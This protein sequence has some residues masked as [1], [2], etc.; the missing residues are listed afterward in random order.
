MDF[1]SISKVK[2]P[3]YFGLGALFLNHEKDFPVLSR[4]IPTS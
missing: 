4:L 1:I 3:C 2:Q